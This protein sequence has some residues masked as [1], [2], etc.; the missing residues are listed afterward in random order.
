MW[1][2]KR[3]IEGAGL[4]R[5]WTQAIYAKLGDLYN[6]ELGYEF[7]SQDTLSKSLGCSVKSL[8][9][10][11]KA[12]ETDG[13]IEALAARKG[14]GLY[15]DGAGKLHGRSTRWKVNWPGV[16]SD[17]VSYSNGDVE[18]DILENESDIL[19]VE[20][21]IVSDKRKPRTKPL[22]SPAS[23]GTPTVS[24][25][26]DA[27]PQPASLPAETVS[28]ESSDRADTH[29]ALPMASKAVKPPPTFRDTPP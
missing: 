15:R 5:G 10:G 28:E 21:D 22:T 11:L 23:A 17:I 26:H 18:S 24:R 14:G 1:Q 12:L 27:L 25:A 19:S 2:L 8:E 6:S 9:R 4:Y 13:R 16:E 20:S 7:A 29:D 3:A